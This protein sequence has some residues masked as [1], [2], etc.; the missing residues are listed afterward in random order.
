MFQLIHTFSQHTEG[1]QVS[2]FFSKKNF[3]K[4]NKKLNICMIPF[5]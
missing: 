5:Q 1:F 2:I 4:R 3:T